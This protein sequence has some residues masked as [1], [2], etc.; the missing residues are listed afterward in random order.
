MSDTPEFD[1]KAFLKTVTTKPGVY[2]M[3]DADDQ[4]LYVGKARNLKNRLSSYFRN[5]GLSSKTWV[6]V[7]HI[8]HIEVTI[9]RTEGEALLLENNLIK[10]HRPRY[11]VLMRDD[12]SYPYIYVSDQGAYPALELHRGARKRKGKYLGPYPNAGAVRETIN[13]LQKTFRVRPCEDSTFRNRSRPCLQY[14]IKRCSAPCVQMTSEEEYA[15]DVRHAVLFL[16]G[17]HGEVI[18]DLVRRME[19]ASS[20]LE[21]ERAA[22]YRDQ[23][24]ALKK[25]QERQSMAGAKGDADVI[26]VASEGRSYAVSAMFIRGGRNLGTRNYFPSAGARVESRQVLSAFIAQ[27]RRCCDRALRRKMNWIL[28]EP[29]RVQEEYRYA[30]PPPSSAS[31]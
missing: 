16:E 31:S 25:V 7:S 10:Q 29:V 2:R 28:T 24:S 26:A 15:G 4:L 14:Q 17:H 11:N 22:H 23:I 8:D 12:K 19:A 27:Y 1:H 20:A 13:L 6:M 5:T 3:Y 21:F 9:T 30:G 18:D